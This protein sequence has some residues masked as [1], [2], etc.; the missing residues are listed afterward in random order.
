MKNNYL[1]II[2][3]GSL[4]ISTQTVAYQAE[5]ELDYLDSEVDIVDIVDISGF[6]GAGTFYLQ[7]IKSG[8]APYAELAFTQRANYVELEYYTINWD[9]PGLSQANK[10]FA[11]KGA[12]NLRDWF[13]SGLYKSL[14]TDS[15]AF[16]DEDPSMNKLEL[17]AGRY[18]APDWLVSLSLVNWS[19]DDNDDGDETGFRL[20]SKRFVRLPS[21]QSF[22]LAGKYFQIDE[23]SEITLAGDF[24]LDKQLSIGASV[25]YLALDDEGIGDDETETGFSARAQYYFNDRFSAKLSYRDYFSLFST[26]N[27][28][29][30]FEPTWTISSSYR[31]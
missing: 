7:S 2:G 22:S 25:F 20:E 21:G 24:Y 26:L 12:Y 9:A 6:R 31:F 4:L 11:V 16:P 18:I 13:F 17:T 10:S 5:V 8:N 14:S 15:D 23:L 29:S 30:F 1:T 19:F 27:E 28:F 3:L